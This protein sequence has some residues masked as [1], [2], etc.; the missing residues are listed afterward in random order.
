M[1]L[2]AYASEKILDFALLAPEGVM[3]RILA[4][5]RSYKKPLKP[6]TDRWHQ[7]EAARRPLEVRL[8]APG[9]MH[10]RAIIIDG[11]TVYTLGQ[12]FNSLAEQGPH[13]PV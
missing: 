7:Q 2:D 8:A 9:T 10:D 13:D 3:V 4:D 11:I 1:M 5:E 6:A 12:S